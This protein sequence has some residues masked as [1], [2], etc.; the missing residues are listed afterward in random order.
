MVRLITRATILRTPRHLYT[1]ELTYFLS[2]TTLSS[3]CYQNTHS[4]NVETE[5]HGGNLPTVTQLM[6]DCLTN[7]D[8]LLCQVL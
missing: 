5:V 8:A 3:K 2:T 7:S 6:C 4:R 1:Q